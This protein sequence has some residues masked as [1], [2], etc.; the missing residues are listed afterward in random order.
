MI[1][2]LILLA[3]LLGAPHPS[4]AGPQAVSL[5][6]APSP[7]T[8]SGVDRLVLPNSPPIIEKHEFSIQVDALQPVSTSESKSVLVRELSPA[9]KHLIRV[10]DFAKTVESFWYR[11]DD[12]SSELCLWYSEYYNTW[13]LWP[14]EKARHLCRG[15]K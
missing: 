5:Y 7:R 3:L 13:S 8:V 11:T 6:V 1:S 10:R 12:S 15:V 9:T 14:L 4:D 2:H